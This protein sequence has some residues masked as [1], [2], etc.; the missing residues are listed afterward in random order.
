MLLAGIGSWILFTVKFITAF[1]LGVVTKSI[2]DHPKDWF[3]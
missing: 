3:N 1:G 2:F